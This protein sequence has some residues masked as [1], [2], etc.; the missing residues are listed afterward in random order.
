M[1]AQFTDPLLIPP[2]LEGTVFNLTV[3][4]SSK[5]FFPGINT[6][7]YGIS[8]DY[9]APTLIFNQGDFIQLNVEN[10][11]PDTTTMHWHGMHVAPSDDRG[12]THQYSQIRVCPEKAKFEIV[13]K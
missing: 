10:N 13:S 1:Q 7:T 12:P 3:A 5:Q 8:A 6:N 9:L 2:T 4:P 11:L